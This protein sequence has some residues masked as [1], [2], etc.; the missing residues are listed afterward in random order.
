MH[1]SLL[2]L[3]VAIFIVISSPTNT[4]TTSSRSATLVKRVSVKDPQLCPDDD[5]V[6]CCEGDLPDNFPKG[7][8][9]NCKESMY[10]FK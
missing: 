4:I 10:F 8:I 1:Y 6:L 7:P 5:V 2:L 9:P 3:I